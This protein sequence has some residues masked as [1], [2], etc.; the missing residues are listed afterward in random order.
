MLRK[1]TIWLLTMLSLVIVLSVYYVTQD[2]TTTVSKYEDS[3][4]GQTAENGESAGEE[5]I[6]S[7]EGFAELRLLLD[8]E[9]SRKVGD[10]ES[11]VANTKLPAAEISKAKDEID[12]LNGLSQKEQNLEVAIK[13]EGYKDVFVKTDSAHAKVTV[14]AEKLSPEQANK[15]LQLARKELKITD[16]TVSHVEK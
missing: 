15:I 8:D 13:A 1:Q 11:V 16:V 10:L 5:E 9:R 6:V 3:K 4:E 14:Q 7:S 2:S 12:E